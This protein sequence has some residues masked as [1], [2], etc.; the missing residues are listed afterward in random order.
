MPLNIEKI[1]EFLKQSSLNQDDQEKFLAILA[2]ESDIELEQIV[3]LFSQD[4]SWIKKLYDNLMQKQQA[5]A[6][7]DKE[8]WK[9]IMQDEEDLLSSIE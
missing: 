3:E 6:N 2:Q 7:K 5:F 9:T 8:L 1:K 4:S